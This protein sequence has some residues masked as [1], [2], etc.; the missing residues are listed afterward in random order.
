MAIENLG[1]TWHSV[2]QA[3]ERMGYIA[4]ALIVQRTVTA[5]AGVAALMAGGGL[6]AVSVVYLG[7][8]V[9]GF[10]VNFFTLRRFLVRPRLSL[11]RSRWLPIM[12]AG[13]PI[14]LVTVLFTAV[15][16]VDQT[17]LSFFEG[18]DNREVGY[19]AAAFRLVEATMFVAWA[20]SGATLPWL[21]RE[22]AEHGRLAR[23]YELGMKVMAGVLLPMALAF[24]L[25]AR[26]WIDLFYGNRYEPAVLPL[27]FWE[28]SRSSTG[29]TPWQ[30]PRSWHAT[31]RSPSF[32]SWCSS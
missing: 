8:A 11:D 10:V 28:A 2:F 13:L 31:G 15:L 22:D 32:R 29:L 3:Y 21:S 14:G 30:R 7:G 5:V 6:I 4:F 27:R 25:F 26:D 1:R 24:A 12:K 18:A 16:K 9:L 17:L 23:G 20:F 19:Y